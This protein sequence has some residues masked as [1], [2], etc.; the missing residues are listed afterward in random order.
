M[1]VFVSV[2]LFSASPMNR[3]IEFLPLA[4]F[5]PRG[6]SCQRLGRLF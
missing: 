1:L 2:G 6:P 3:Q 5:H 4:P